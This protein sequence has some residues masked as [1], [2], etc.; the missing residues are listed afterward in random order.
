[1][2]VTVTERGR[3]ME[4]HT[5]TCSVEKVA[6]PYSCSAEYVAHLLWDTLCLESCRCRS[7]WPSNDLSRVCSR[8]RWGSIGWQTTTA[9][10]FLASPNTRLCRDVHCPELTLL[11]Q[12]SMLTSTT[13]SSVSDQEFT[14]VEVS[15]KISNRCCLLCSETRNLT[16]PSACRN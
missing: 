10:P 9:Q 13:E 8:M 14:S 2:V 5:S 15:L 16:K 12:D 6:R 4:L 1:M 11:G 7:S 3:G